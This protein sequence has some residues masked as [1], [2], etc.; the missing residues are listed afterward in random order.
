MREWV[1]ILLLAAV[2]FGG[3]EGKYKDDPRLARIRKELPAKKDAAVQ[4]GA[5]AEARTEG[6]RQVLV[7][8]T[9]YLVLGAYDVDRTLVHE[10]FHCLH[11]ARLGTKDYA[12]LPEWVREGA[13]VYVAGQG[14][15]RARILAAFV[16]RDPRIDEPLAR[17]VDGLGGQHGFLDYYEDVAAFEATEERHG[18]DGVRRLLRQLLET[19]DV[20]RA[21]RAALDESL[22]AFERAA[23]ARARRVLA[24]L[25]EEGRASIL[26]ARRH[27]EAEEPADA[28][29]VLE[30]LEEAGVY[31][32]AA[33]Y[34][35]AVALHR[36]GR[37][38][39][40][41][42]HL[43]EHF[44]GRHR[45]ATTLLDRALR[46]ELDLLEASESG[47]L[48]VAKARAALDLTVYP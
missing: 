46:L 10:L 14:G 42:R 28:L 4:S 6:K 26:E 45:A 25:L 2:V 44:L 20:S 5:W 7:L 24:P 8:K 1:A 18:R 11:R 23:A 15:E 27:L 16:G 12:R 43:R 40:A 47:E 9:E 34:Y 33:A 37:H 48:E 22:A 38:A 31:A 36:V 21:V 19:A 17:L 29:E 32:P 3:Y 13:A 41:L 30:A 35:R 39:D